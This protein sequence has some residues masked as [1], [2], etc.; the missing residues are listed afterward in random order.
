M[1]EELRLKNRKGRKNMK[2]IQSITNCMCKVAYHLL[3]TFFHFWTKAKDE[4]FICIVSCFRALDDHSTKI[5]K[6]RDEKIYLFH[7]YILF[8]S[9]FTFRQID[10]DD[11]CFSL[12]SFVHMYRLFRNIFHWFEMV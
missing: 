7:V 10:A 6:K 2:Q 11:T 8:C 9:G 12:G 3:G 4:H 5:L 1:F